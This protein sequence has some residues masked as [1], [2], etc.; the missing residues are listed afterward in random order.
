M[1][2]ELHRF[3]FNDDGDHSRWKKAVEA[4]LKAIV[5]NP[6]LN[7]GS[8]QSEIVFPVTPGSRRGS[9][10]TTTPAEINGAFFAFYTVPD[11]TNA[12][13]IHLQGGTINGEPVDTTDLKLY[14]LSLEDWQSANVD[15]HLYVP[16]SG[17]FTVVDRVALPGFVI[18][19]VGTPVIGVPPGDTYP[20]VTG[21]TTAS[22]GTCNVSLG[23]FVG[24]G[25]NVTGFMPAR[26]GN[27]VISLCI[28]PPYSGT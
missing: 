6:H 14:D 5:T 18:T 23:V 10:G 2:S 25:A 8:S 21:E 17:K 26:A 20:A 22:A 28:T 7:I 24:E 16:V 11:G 27:R 19:S 1:S 9:A 3:G 12:G 4:L 15:D 13:D